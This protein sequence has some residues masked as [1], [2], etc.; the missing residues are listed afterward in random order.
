MEAEKKPKVKPRNLPENNGLGPAPPIP[1]HRMFKPFT[2]NEVRS[3]IANAP[4]TISHEIGIKNEVSHDDI[5]K[6]NEDVTPDDEAGTSE[7]Q[8]TE[9]GKI[10]VPE[11][12]ENQIEIEDDIHDYHNIEERRK[13][14]TEKR[15]GVSPKVIEKPL[16]VL[17]PKEENPPPLPP[18]QVY[19][20]LDNDIVVAEMDGIKSASLFEQFQVPTIVEPNVE[21]KVRYPDIN[22]STQ[23]R[24]QSP[25]EYMK[26]CELMTEGELLTY[27]QNEQLEFIDDFIDVFIGEELNPHHALFDLLQMYKDVCQKLQLTNDAKESTVEQLKVLNNEVW[28]VEDKVINQT[29]CSVLFNFISKAFDF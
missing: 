2:E 17:L 5:E 1:T 27:Y 23:I 10:I 6:T 25:M 13:E 4:E 28:I 11:E 18:R 22:E 21:E 24:H 3:V 16:T 20:K 7:K 29:V 19:P 9:E 14:S 15:G 12:E 8:V 26:E